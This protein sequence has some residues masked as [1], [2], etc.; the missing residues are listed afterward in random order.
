ME[1]NKVKDAL[2]INGNGDAETK[3][4]RFVSVL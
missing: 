1:M 3:G 4:K 2:I